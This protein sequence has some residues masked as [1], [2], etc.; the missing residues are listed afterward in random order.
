MGP[1]LPGRASLLL[2]QNSQH[3]QNHAISRVKN[4]ARTMQKLQHIRIYDRSTAPNTWSTNINHK[5][6]QRTTNEYA[7]ECRIYIN[8]L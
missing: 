7:E 2:T 5:G 4:M 6:L 1:P 3:P 8:T